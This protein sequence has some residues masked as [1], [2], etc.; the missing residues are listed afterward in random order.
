M[1]YPTHIVI[2]PII[3]SGIR[4]LVSRETL[5][6]KSSEIG[7][8]FV[9]PTPKCVLKTTEMIK[10]LVYW[11]IST[12]IDAGKSSGVLDLACR[13]A[14]ELNAPLIVFQLDRFFGNTPPVYPPALSSASP[15][16]VAGTLLEVYRSKGRPT[17]FRSQ[18]V[19]VFP[20]RSS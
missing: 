2:E 12:P 10:G 8:V 5:L 1:L 4:G 18:N 3:Q 17:S 13:G 15:S 9:N 20:R 19:T 7:S 6:K 14:Y 11:L 16:A